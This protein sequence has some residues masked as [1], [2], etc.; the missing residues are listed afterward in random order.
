MINGAAEI[1]IAVEET[2]GLN[3]L[4]EAAASDGLDLGGS[5]PTDVQPPA[6]DKLE[7]ALDPIEVIAENPAKFTTAELVT[8]LQRIA[9]GKDPEQLV[10]DNLSATQIESIRR[11]LGKRDD[12]AFFLTVEMFKLLYPELAN[13]L[14]G[15]SSEGVPAQILQDATL[16]GDGS[17][18]ELTT[19]DNGEKKRVNTTGLLVMIAFFVWDISSGH[20]SQTLQLL[21]NEGTKWTMK[22]LGFSNE[23]VDSVVGN[24]YGENGVV[25]ALVEKLNEY[26][27]NQLLVKMSGRELLGFL[28]GLGQDRRSKLMQGEDFSDGISEKKCDKETL[29]YIYEQFRNDGIGEDE[30][31]RLGLIF[32]VPSVTAT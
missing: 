18:A 16:N 9:Q 20:G 19:V 2:N 24:N 4:G 3:T 22:K 12:R 26:E 17:Q 23:L 6:D 30:L 31:K 1:P 13:V 21:T 15:V 8:T 29:D 25:Q 5:P 7:V 10:G 32:P 28:E 27:L 11:E 14:D